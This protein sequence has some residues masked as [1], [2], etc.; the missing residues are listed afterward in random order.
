MRLEFKL[1]D[2]AEGMMEG[3][4]VHW[5]VAPGD[6][7][8]VEQPVVEVMTDK[9]TVVIPSPHEGEIVQLSHEVGDIVAVGSTLF[10]MDVD[11][12]VVS[13]QVEASSPASGAPEAASESHAAAPRAGASA[14]G[15]TLTLAS[16]A[17]SVRAAAQWVPRGAGKTLATPATRRL[18]REL[19]VD[20]EQVRGTGP[21]GRVTADD[22]R[23]FADETAPRS[24]LSAAPRSPLAPAS[25]APEV[26]ASV[27]SPAASAPA[28]PAYRYEAQPVVGEEGE[29]RVRLRG[30]RRAI[31][32]TMARSTR[33]A[34]HFTYV[35]EI[36]CENLVSARERLKGAAEG[37]GVRLT[38][39][40]FIAKAVLLALRRFPKINAS[41]DDE[42]QEIV[43]KRHYH[44]GVAAATPAGLVVPVVRHADRLTLLDLAGHIQ[45]LGAGARDGRLKPDQ[46][47]GSTFTITSLGRLGGLFATPVINH[48]E[49]AIL[50]VHQMQQRAVV[51]DDQIVARRMMN[52]SL[53]FDHRVIDGHEGAAFTQEVRRYLED[54]GLMMLEMV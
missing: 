3:E 22:V 6:T 1:P 11:G 51:R 30:L 53:S 20:I 45:E 8:R 12:D 2:L 40:P 41:M 50:G 34:A 46:L 37:R 23:A 31:Y 10:V 43:L 24:P 9:A 49:V 26:R 52:L 35:E 15:G 17:P 44:L 27:P 14:R 48:P 33:T 32:E 39:L 38:Y 7:V 21:A 18:A 28:A 16:A 5:L 25:P 4:V 29:E 13:N 42:A 36:D 19:G 54:P 47:R